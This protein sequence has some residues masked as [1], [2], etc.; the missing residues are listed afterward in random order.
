M[1]KHESSAEFPEDCPPEFSGGE[2]NYCFQRV[3]YLSFPVADSAT[4][5]DDVLYQ[6][7][8]ESH[9]QPPHLVLWNYASEVWAGFVKGDYDQICCVLLEYFMSYW[10]IDCII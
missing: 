5:S 2:V 6:V 10:M 1:L 7:A 4:V 9:V 8:E 3:V